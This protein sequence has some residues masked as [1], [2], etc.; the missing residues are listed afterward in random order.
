MTIQ[1]I[2]NNLPT[3]AKRNVL[4]SLVGSL[5]ANLVG[6]AASIAS[7]LERDEYDIKELSR[8]EVE[9]LLNAGGET[10]S[11]L[12]IRKLYRVAQGLRDQ[13][14]EITNDDSQGALSNT[15]DFMV[16]GTG[17]GLDTELLKTTLEAAGVK[18]VDPAHIE[19]MYKQNNA[20]RA[21]RLS[22]QRGAIEWLLDQVFTSAHEI[23]KFNKAGKFIGYENIVDEVD[24]LPADMHDRVVDKLRN[25][26][27]RARDT[28]ILGVLNRDRR[29]SFGDLPLISAA[30]EEAKQI[31]EHDVAEA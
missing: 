2:I 9:T 12:H 11:L 10:D 23:E 17:R 24:D 6:A 8:S 7:R 21:A 20:Q 27:D 28:A 25:A 4:F 29:Y 13:L 14:I 3:E 31:R 18:N 16:S 15:I 19:Q 26:L 1:A 22:A 30:I 5:N